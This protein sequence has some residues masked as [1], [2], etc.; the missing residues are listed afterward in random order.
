[1]QTSWGSLHKR[2][3]RRSI[4][5]AVLAKTPDHYG[6]IKQAY[7]SPFLL[8][9]G[10]QGDSLTSEVNLHHARLKSFAWWIRG[11]GYAE[12]LPD[13]EVT[14]NLMETH[15]LILFGGPQTNWITKK[16]AP[17]LPITLKEGRVTLG[18]KTLDSSQL[19][20]QLIYPNPL[21][22]KR[23]ILLHAGTSLQ[24]DSSLGGSI[25][26][27]TLYSGAGLPD[28]ILYDESLKRKGWGGVLVCGFFDSHWQLKE[29]LL[30]YKLGS[31]KDISVE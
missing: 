19:A 24:V 10:T 7:F 1:M 30:F 9:Y 22:P 15:N 16:I 29:E 6:P 23:F 28:F 14:P 21:N 11:N 26:L 5:S 18:K 20:L 31:S 4:R 13:T 12:I 3:S 27:G 8:V 2:R 25:R 17:K